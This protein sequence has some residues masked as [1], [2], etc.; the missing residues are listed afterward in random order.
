MVHN[1]TLSAV[2]EDNSSE[3][4]DVGG[5][6]VAVT[7]LERYIVP[8]VCGFGLVGN[9]A[10]VVVLRR[11]PAKATVCL[12]TALA[13]TDWLFLLLE[14]VSVYIRDFV[15]VDMD[16]IWSVL[17]HS[18]MASVWLVVV[19]S[20]ERYIIVC[21]PLH[22]HSICTVGNAKRII[23]IV[24]LLC[25]VY[26]S[27]DYIH[28]IVQTASDDSRTVGRTHSIFY[29]MIYRSVLD[30]LVLFLIP[31]NVLFI[32]NI[33]LIKS[34]GKAH[35]EHSL[36]S[37]KESD[38][39]TRT[40]GTRGISPK[41]STTLNIIT[42][43]SVFLLTQPLI[44]VNNIWQLDHQYLGQAIFNGDCV[45]MFRYVIRPSAV[46][47]LAV[48]S[49]LN[50]IIYTLFYRKFRNYIKMKLCCCFSRSHVEG[51]IP[52]VQIRNVV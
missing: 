46:C 4:W 7:V 33:K 36:L 44:L 41:P 19:L 13:A 40:E 25:V 16:L 2:C 48:P 49:A 10:A 20:L 34:I 5:F 39:S 11:L 29:F 8:L 37:Q 43:V 38:G 28:M 42:V 50:F 9:L 23:R 3:T 26:I 52:L 14:L 32:L 51:Q 45:E 1:S 12:L 35:R 31:F 17:L 21:H 15:C 6:Q 22:V 47:L 24:L 30:P 27:F 18:R